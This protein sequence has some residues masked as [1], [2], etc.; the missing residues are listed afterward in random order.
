L[1]W[2]SQQ[3]R[4]R[5][6]LERLHE[7]SLVPRWELCIRNPPPQ[8]V[9]HK[10]QSRKHPKKKQPER[11]KKWNRGEASAHRSR[12]WLLRWEMRWWCSPAWWGGKFSSEESL[13]FGRGEFGL[14]IRRARR[15]GRKPRKVMIM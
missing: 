6:Y 7:F 9:S 3:E 2:S 1:K 4:K 15:G 8:T 10:P 5:L 13:G 11:D 12:S 14:R